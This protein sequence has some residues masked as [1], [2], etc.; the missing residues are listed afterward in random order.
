MERFWVGKRNVID[1]R[2]QRSLVHAVHAD[3][4]CK[5]TVNSELLHGNTEKLRKDLERF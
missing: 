3:K 2:L 4:R 1:T 5:A